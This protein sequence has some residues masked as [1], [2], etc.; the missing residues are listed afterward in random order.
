[1]GLLL[2][3]GHDFLNRHTVRELTKLHLPQDK[4]VGVQPVDAC[5]D[6]M[7]GGQGTAGTH[8]LGKTRPEFI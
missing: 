7:E 1:M 8:S 5:E 6:E 4:Q 2:D 3:A